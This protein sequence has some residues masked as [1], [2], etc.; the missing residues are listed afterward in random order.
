MEFH[1]DEAGCSGCARCV[2]ACPE[3]ILELHEKRPRFEPGADA[4]CISCG[5]CVMACSTGAA[6]H[7][8]FTDADF[9]PVERGEVGFDGLVRLFSARRSVRRFKDEPVPRELIDK[10]IEATST[11]PMGFPPHT[12]EVLVFNDRGKIQELIPHMVKGYAG[13]EGA[14]ANPV[15][16][17]FVKRAVG[18]PLYKALETHV[19]P[20]TKRARRLYEERKLER[21]LWNAP[22]LLLF[23]ADRFATSNLENT[24]IAVTYAMLAAHALGLGTLVNGLLPPI[25]DRSKELRFKLGIP[26]DNQVQAALLLG[27]AKLQYKRGIRRKLRKVEYV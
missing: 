7:S 21:Y 25:V 11:A 14:V 27:F 13:L 24:W 22:A 4:D 10:V 6:R 19:I 8:A 2:E 17:F 3:C 16:R 26:R 15:A 9:Y 12:T 23:H 1:G 5:H 20:V 18:A